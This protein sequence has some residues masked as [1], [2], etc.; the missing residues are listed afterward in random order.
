MAE[1]HYTGVNSDGEEV[2]GAISATTAEGARSRIRELGVEPREI[3]PGDGR[4]LS[5]SDATDLA[6]A[7]SN[8]IQADVPLAAGLRAAAAESP[9]RRLSKVCRRLANELN[10][11]YPLD[12]AIARLRPDIPDHIAGLVQAAARTQNVSTVLDE[13]VG[14][15]VAQRSRWTHVFIATAYP[16]F[17]L[18]F[19]LCLFIGFT[20]FVVAPFK[21]LFEDWSISLPL[22]TKTLIWWH[23]IGAWIL[24]AIVLLVIAFVGFAPM[25]AGPARF[26]RMLAGLPVIGPIFHWAGIAEMLRLLSLLIDA[27]ITLP[28]ALRLSAS[29]VSDA[30]VREVCTSY[31]AR[32]ENGV[33]LTR[34]VVEDRAVPITIAP[35]LHWGELNDRLPEALQVAAESLEERLDARAELLQGVF[36][37]FVFIIVAT[38]TVF[39]VL[40]LLLPMAAMLR[41]I[42]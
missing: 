32:A 13:L 29:G 21:Q 39:G 7:I 42:Y 27:G 2:R 22:V 37:P 15:R 6:V 26:R 24:A 8:A 38:L 14:L 9:S 33:S 16:I 40:A 10:Q 34:L 19:G 30:F 17:V 25:I 23:D 31:G 41:G 20:I 12:E 36:P 4:Q 1:F 11:G 28:E 18:L 35:L 5:S 3:L